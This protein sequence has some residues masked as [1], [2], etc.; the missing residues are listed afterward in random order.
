MAS[1]LLSFK[2]LVLAGSSIAL[3]LTLT[4]C[5]DNTATSTVEIP[6]GL[7]EIT[8]TVPAEGTGAVSETTAPED[9]AEVESI[10]APNL[11][12]VSQLAAAGN[13]N[14]FALSIG[15]ATVIYDPAG[16]PDWELSV[17]GGDV[18]AVEI[19]NPKQVGKA[20]SNA[21]VKGAAEG[22]ATL[23]ATNTRTGD[24]VEFTLTVE[25]SN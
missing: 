6:A 20:K 13:A 22:E 23:T 19:S 12:D 1:N 21:S 14:R 3:A 2:K 25:G 16:S 15:Q 5:S 24:T 11:I 18:N 17:T 8:E 7:E 9:S 10:P 4:A